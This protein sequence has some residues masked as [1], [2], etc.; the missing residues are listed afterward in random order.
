MS[1]FKKILKLQ[2]SAI[3]PQKCICCSELIDENNFLCKKCVESIERNNMNDIC[4]L[5]GF[6]KDEC[7]CKYNVYHFNSLL[8]VFKNCGLAQNAYYNYKFYK[9]Q[10]YA[11]FFAAEMC[12]AIKK[13][14]SEIKF[15]FICSVPSFEKNGY[16]HS[17]YLAEITAKNLNLTYKKNILSCV[18]KVKKQHKSS[19][20]ERLLNTEGKYK[21]NYRIDNKNVLLIDD[22]KTTGATLDECA[23][24]LLFAGA[25]SV[26]CITV[27]GSSTSKK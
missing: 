3:Y 15:D 21:C 13:H 6:E 24:E 25:N 14:F 10:H 8:C 9:K 26:Y 2:I 18:K 12:E 11:K 1:I 19:I 22:I 17:G 4:L 27:L 7:V 20:K 23:K 16:D 5:C